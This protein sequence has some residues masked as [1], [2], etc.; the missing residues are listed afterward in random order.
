LGLYQCVFCV[1]GSNNFDNIIN[2]IGN[3]HPSK[4]PIYCERS[5]EKTDEVCDY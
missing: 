3:C 4:P 1:F 5:N 2:H